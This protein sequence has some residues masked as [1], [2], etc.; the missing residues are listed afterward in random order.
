M[1]SLLD[2]LNF[3]L[4][5]IRLGRQ[6]YFEHETFDYNF[7]FVFFFLGNMKH[8]FLIIFSWNFLNNLSI[9]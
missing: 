8:L 1:N 4:I 3:E 2:Y 6:T 7:D 5:N 9:C